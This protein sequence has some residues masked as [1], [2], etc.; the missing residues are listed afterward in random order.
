MSN[1]IFIKLIVLSV[2]ICVGYTF[3]SL[4]F[5]PS[6]CLVVFVGVFGVYILINFFKKI[7]R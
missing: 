3:V 5:N 6:F 1:Q 4:T 2:F 7:F